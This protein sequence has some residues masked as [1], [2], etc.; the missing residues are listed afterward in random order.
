[1]F[2]NMDMDALKAEAKRRGVDARGSQTTLAKRLQTHVDTVRQTLMQMDQADLEELSASAGV[3]TDPGQGRF[4]RVES[5]LLNGVD[6]EKLLPD[7]GPVAE[8]K[9]DEVTPDGTVWM[10][11]RWHVEVGSAEHEEL[12]RQGHVPTDAPKKAGPLK[13]E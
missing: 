6:L 10:G 12:I 4:E 11:G 7:A 13:P 3:A 2:E 8:D 9:K 1:M 5:L